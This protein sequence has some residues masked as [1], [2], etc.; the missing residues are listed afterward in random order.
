[1][2][3]NVN[4]KFEELVEALNDDT[5]S[6]VVTEIANKKI[7]NTVWSDVDTKYWLKTDSKV[8]INGFSNLG[9]LNNWSLATKKF[10]LQA[11][12]HSKLLIDNKL[13]NISVVLNKLKKTSYKLCRWKWVNN[14][15]YINPWDT[16]CF[17]WN[18]NKII[19]NSNLT[20]SWK[21]TNIIINWENNK[22]IFKKS[23]S[24]PWYLN[25]F[26]DKGYVLFDNNINLEK[27]DI[28]GQVV[29]NNNVTKW[30]VFR[31]NIFVNWLIAWYDWSN[32]SHFKHKM[33]IYGSVGSLNTIWKN[34]ARERYVQNNTYFN[35]EFVDVARVFNWFCTDT[36]IW[37]D[38]VDCSN[39]NDK[40]LFNSLII[41]KVDYKKSL[42]K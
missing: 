9:W 23:Q 25:V 13:L 5:V 38:W 30:A 11:R 2:W 7:K 4:T 16:I 19:V 15:S 34:Q 39:T 26:V 18:D 17:K 40:Y 21:V 33:Y 20:S 14:I 24:G 32:I 42:L 3:W 31:W 28:N 8:F 27:L 41:Q 29:Q 12:K 6:D 1:V 37:V 36:W 22:L 10:K 35:K